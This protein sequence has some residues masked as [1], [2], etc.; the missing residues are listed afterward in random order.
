M[1]LVRYA[2]FQQTFDPLPNKLLLSLT[3]NDNC[4][5]LHIVVVNISAIGTKMKKTYKNTCLLDKIVS[6]TDTVSAHAS[7]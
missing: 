6:T 1:G 3:L 2:K 4:W 5:L 7:T